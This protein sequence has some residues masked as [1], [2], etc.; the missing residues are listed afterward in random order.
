MAEAV[1]V[2]VSAGGSS[3]AS[4]ACTLSQDHL[5]L[6]LKVLPTFQLA[7]SSPKGPSNLD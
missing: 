4:P 7:N 5:S 2:G 1:P 3:H 6:T